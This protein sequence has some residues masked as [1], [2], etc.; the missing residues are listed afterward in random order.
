MYHAVILCYSNIAQLLNVKFPCLKIIFVLFC[1]ATE[2][3]LIEK[4][5]KTP[6]TLHQ[7]I[8]KQ[9]IEV[10]NHKNII[11]HFIKQR[12]KLVEN[13]H[14]FQLSFYFVCDSSTWCHLPGESGIRIWMWTVW[15]KTKHRC[16]L[17]WQWRLE[18]HSLD[19]MFIYHISSFHWS[20]LADS[21]IIFFS[22]TKQVRRRKNR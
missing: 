9:Q 6:I 13:S 20:T 4:K 22:L 19:H 12:K 2:I 14:V 17:A 5:E 8:L 1:I 11:L 7:F 15:F 10:T 21:R 16:V 18:C 3:T